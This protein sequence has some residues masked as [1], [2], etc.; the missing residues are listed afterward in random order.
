MLNFRYRF[1]L[2]NLLKGF[3]GLLVIVVLYILLQKYTAFDGFIDHIGQWPI[4]VYVVF[5]LSEVVFGIIPPELFMIWSIKH[6][7]F[8]VY[9][10][11]ILFLATISYTA[12]VVGYNIGVNAS[13][14]GWLENLLG[15]Y[16]YRY[17]NTL[18]KFGGLLIFVGAITPIPFSAICMLVGAT[19]F[20][21]PKF[22]L[23]ALAR[24]ARFI[25]YAAVIYQANI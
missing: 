24:F 6:G 15:K 7:I 19:G 14:I 21:F 9:F 25:V 22:L 2:K 11:D 8:N 4:L 10:L 3:I 1:L 18:N 17:K 23:I 12:G 13:K 20:P 16:I 5:T